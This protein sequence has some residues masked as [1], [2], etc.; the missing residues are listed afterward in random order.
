MA[1][2]LSV[3][4]PVPAV[5]RR[6]SKELLDTIRN[7]VKGALNTPQASTTGVTSEDSGVAAVA[8]EDE[9]PS[10]AD[11]PSISTTVASLWGDGRPS[12][13]WVHVQR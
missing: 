1:A 11:A 9:A 6:R 12:S 13:C 3:F 2:L 8:V 10:A 4:H 5:V 7:S